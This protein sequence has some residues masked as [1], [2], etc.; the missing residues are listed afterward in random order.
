[1]ICEYDERYLPE[2]HRLLF[3][4]KKIVGSVVTEDLA[5]K[6][7]L[8]EFGKRFTPY[9]KTFLFF[10]DN[11]LVAFI[12]SR[13]LKEFPSWYISMMTSKPQRRL[14]L[15][16]SGLRELLTKT[17]EYWEEE[18][19]NSFFVAQTKTHSFSLNYM[20]NDSVPALSKYQIPAHVV[21]VV[22]KDTRSSNTMIDELL[23]HN[24]FS[25]DMVVKW[26]HKRIEE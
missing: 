8:E 17:I 1:M 10:K 18:G 22:P 9:V 12:C 20:L 7:E 13:K 15:T 14:D 21:E 6:S 3:S 26:V 24:T 2:M 25:E 5:K 23:K 16:N 4:H 19:L 11:E